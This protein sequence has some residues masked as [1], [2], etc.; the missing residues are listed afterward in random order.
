MLSAFSKVRWF[1]FT[2]PLVILFEDFPQLVIGGIY[3]G[4]VGTEDAGGIAVFAFIMSLTS[5]LC[6]VGLFVYDL[7]HYWALQ[8]YVQMPCSVQHRA[9]S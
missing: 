3:L 9:G 6:N 5:V 2:T 8:S 1:V 4:A 7:R